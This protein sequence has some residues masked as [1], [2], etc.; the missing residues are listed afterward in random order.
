M[1]AFASWFVLLADTQAQS[2]MSIRCAVLAWFKA[3]SLHAKLQ[4]HGLPP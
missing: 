1:H 2:D 4:I 3:S